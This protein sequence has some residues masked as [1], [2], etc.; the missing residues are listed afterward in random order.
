[1]SAKALRWWFGVSVKTT[2]KW[3]KALRVGRIDNPGSNALVRQASELG[4]SRQRGK[5]LPQGWVER[6][7]RR[8]PE[9]NLGRRLQPGYHGPRWTDDQLPLLG[10]LPDEEVAV[11]TVL[12]SLTRTP[13][14]RSPSSG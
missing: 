12:R 8:A 4:A 2:W 9:E 13:T 5:K 10:T 11:V 3:R 6:C 1:M 7:R 14:R